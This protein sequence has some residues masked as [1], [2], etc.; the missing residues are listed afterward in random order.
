MA[1]KPINRLY[2]ILI[3]IIAGI[4][5][6]FAARSRFL[7][8]RQVDENRFVSTY[9]ALSISREKYISEPDS[10]MTAV[11]NIYGRNGTDSTWM[12]DYGKKL[13]KDLERSEHVWV[14][15]AAKLDSLRKISNVDS[16]LVTLQDHP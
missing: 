3:L 6:V 8:Q 13:S 1:A 14:R 4:A 7:Y 10:L 5:A 16:A 15:I 2:L 12:A 11:D 9:L